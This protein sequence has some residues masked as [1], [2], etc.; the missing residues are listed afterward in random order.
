MTESV[1]FN[2]SLN[3]TPYDPEHDACQ[4]EG[5]G[6]AGST[7]KGTEGAGGAPNAPPE[8]EYSPNC[9]TELLKT[10]GTCGSA[11]L[12]SKTFPPGALMAGFGCVASAMDWVECMYEPETKPQ[13][14]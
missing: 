6:G 12:A 4:S 8:S 5:T 2:A 1:G 7:A 11:Y 9:T 3:Y 14:Q 10:I 13:G